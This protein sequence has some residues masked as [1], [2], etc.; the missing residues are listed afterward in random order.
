[1]AKSPFDVRHPLFRPLWRRVVFVA[2]ILSWT[3]Y[4]AANANY[5]WAAVFGAAGLYLLWAFFL[6]FDPADYEDE[7]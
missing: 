6:V 4:E 2:A 7:G 3:V 1:M 5:V